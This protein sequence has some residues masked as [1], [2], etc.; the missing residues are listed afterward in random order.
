M[1]KNIRQVKKQTKLWV[2]LALIMSAQSIQQ[3]NFQ[4]DFVSTLLQTESDMSKS[5]DEMSE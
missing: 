2:I 1:A 4:E 5:I 3:K